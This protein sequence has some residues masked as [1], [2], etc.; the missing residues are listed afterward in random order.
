MRKLLGGKNIL[1]ILFIISLFSSF[2]VTNS[3]NSAFAGIWDKDNVTYTE[4]MC[5][6]MGLEWEPG[7]VFK[8][9]KVRYLEKKD[10][11]YKQT[12]DYGSGGD[13]EAGNGG[14]H[15]YA[16][17][18]QKDASKPCASGFK[19]ETIEIDNFASE[20]ACV[21]TD[22][23]DDKD[24]GLPPSLTN[25]DGKDKR[26]KL[27][28]NNCKNYGGEF[29]ISQKAFVDQPGKCIFRKEDGSEIDYE[30]DTDLPDT[31]YTY[32]KDHKC[33]SGYKEEHKTAG[34]TTAA[35]CTKLVTNSNGE[36]VPATDPSVAGKTEDDKDEGKSNCKVDHF[37]WIVCPGAKAMGS[38][39]SGLYKSIAD[40]FL[41]V[42][43]GQ[44]FQGDSGAKAA[45]QSFRDI[46]NVIFIIAIMAIVISQ[47]TG[48]GISN[49]GIKK[50]LPKILVMA[51]LINLSW[52]VAVIGVDISNILGKGIFN[53]FTS[54]NNDLIKS[55]NGGLVENIALILSGSA[56]AVIGLGVIA[57]SFGIFFALGVALLALFSFFVILTVRQAVIILLVV[58][59]PLA[60]ACLVFPNM[61]KYFDKWLSMFKSLL[62]IY[63]ICSAIMGASILASTILGKSAGGKPFES[64][65][66]TLIP[67]MALFTT[68]TIIKT[69]LSALGALG[70]TISGK[71]SGMQK[72]GANKIRNNN[73]DNGIKR[74]GNNTKLMKGINYGFDIKGKRV[75][76][77]WKTRHTIAGMKQAEFERDEKIRSAES[78]MASFEG[79]DPKDMTPG[80]QRAYEGAKRLMDSVQKEKHKEGIEAMSYSIRQDK[81]NPA[82]KLIDLAKK[83]DKAGADQLLTAMNSEMSKGQTSDAM[84]NFL[85]Y[86]EQNSATMGENELNNYRQVA[87]SMA[88]SAQGGK[89][90]DHDIVSHTQLQNIASGNGKTL[91][92][93]II[94]SKT[95]TG[96]SG[97]AAAN[98]GDNAKNNYALAQEHAKNSKNDKAI[99][100]F[101]TLNNAARASSNY[102]VKD[103]SVFNNDRFNN[104]S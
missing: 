75:W 13:R 1:L 87:S 62:F 40:N 2:F 27:D 29:R 51:I 52:Y 73:L 59:S 25:A 94:D 64:I 76:K 80:Q 104:P 24:Y 67:A 45:W 12:G 99:E 56:A 88:N 7:V 20:K 63:P 81:I 68:G 83:G 36:Q 32:S 53:L 69:A 10:G 31:F 8:G 15:K 9:C 43:S 86:Y 54:A 18:V 22:G 4:S 42:K 47:I 101:K 84:R 38:M 72:F 14:M 17:Y 33:P 95:Y 70:S 77:G 85:D 92:E 97:V 44:I 30:Y 79:M 89:I 16:A 21:K 19:S 90:K 71:L 28:E 66:F 74:W 46:G 50:M 55:T 5:K 82:D 58:V 103:A 6:E 61:N 23:L 37:G 102:A 57:M 98:Q 41:S 49:Y 96:L 35:K 91:K 26:V 100:Q 11:V 48:Y 65:L 34:D 93:T 60:F 39:V 78:I 3:S